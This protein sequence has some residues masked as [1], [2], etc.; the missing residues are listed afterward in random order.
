[1]SY[2]KISIYLA[3]FA[4]AMQENMKTHR[5]IYLYII[6]TA[7]ALLAAAA[8]TCIYASRKN[9]AQ[10]QLSLQEQV[11]RLLDTTKA[12]VGMAVYY[13]GRMICGHNL[14]KTYPMMS[15]FKLYQ[16]LAVLDS[17]SAFNTAAGDTLPESASDDRRNASGNTRHE[18]SCDSQAEVSGNGRAARVPISLE[19]K[20]LITKDM[21]HE[22]TYSPMRDSYPGGGVE[23]SIEE[24]LR[25]SL[26]QSDNNACDILFSLFG[27]PAYVQSRLKEWGFNKSQV[28]WTEVDMHIDEQR[29]YDN[30][31]T[32][33]EAVKIVEM[34]FENPWLRSVLAECA[35]GTGRI[36]AGITRNTTQHRDQAAAIAD[37]AKQGSNATADTTEKDESPGRGRR[38][39]SEAVTVGHKTGTWGETKDGKVNGINDIGYVLFPDGHH[40]FISVFCNDSSLDIPG[41]E[42][43]IAEVSK[44]TY[45]YFC[46]K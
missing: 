21:L 38:T 4:T 8:L 6:V 29:A 30:Y 31:T 24:L 23:L 36:P 40:Y 14:D 41:T 13:D 33:Q 44:L 2:A 11:D 7:A 15:V 18:A 19:T 27:G 25:W 32:P 12:D 22:N 3:N 17:L 35:T 39:A 10:A 34:A 16:A 42:A 46:Y 43:I 28:L 20:V 1:M 37:S 9:A 5:N 26:L 45:E